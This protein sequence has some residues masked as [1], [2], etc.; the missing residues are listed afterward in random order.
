MGNGGRVVIKWEMR[1]LWG[2]NL[3]NMSSV[4]EARH[5]ATVCDSIYMNCQNR[6]AY[7]D[8]M[9]ISVGAGRGGGGWRRVAEGRGK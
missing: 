1:K 3:E 5:K 6:Q 2:K 9:W 4:R 7:R 8:K